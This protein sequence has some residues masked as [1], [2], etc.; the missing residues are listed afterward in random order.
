V[1]V[2]LHEAGHAA[3]AQLLGFRITDIGIAGLRIRREGR[4]WRLARPGLA[5]DWLGYVATRPQHPRNL[6]LRV[7]IMTVAGP[8]VS[9]GVSLLSGL[10]T[11]SDPARWPMAITSMDVLTRY[12]TRYGSSGAEQFVL[13]TL[14]STIGLWSLAIGVITLLPKVENGF[15]QS[16]GAWIRALVKP[17]PDVGRWLAVLVLQSSSIGG[18]RPR[19]WDPAVV[20]VALE[21]SPGTCMMP[22]SM[23]YNWYADTKQTEEA[24]RELDG[25]LS[26]P[27]PAAMPLAWWNGWWFEAAWFALHAQGNLEEAQK[28]MQV[29]ESLAQP[30]ENQAWRWRA[31]AVIAA[32]EGR[33]TDAR[34]AA[35]KAL[36]LNAGEGGD[37]GIMKGIR[38]DIAELLAGISDARA[39]RCDF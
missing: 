26:Q 1:A 5:K 34:N 21:K 2:A 12:A 15:P 9:F 38:E 10:L 7:L 6:K 20:A 4:S 22:P 24:K 30:Q 8:A 35:E 16:D 17:G 14:P 3:A 39:N 13:A 31:L 27:C 18:L 19:E 25:I 28:C 23:R 36:T 32:A 11:A 29:A 33:R 37:A